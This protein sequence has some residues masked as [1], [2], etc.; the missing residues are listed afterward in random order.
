LPA[1]LSLHVALCVSRLI[2]LDSIL[3][4]VFHFVRASLSSGPFNRFFFILGAVLSLPLCACPSPS[5]PD[6]S[7]PPGRCAQP[8]LRQAPILGCS[9]SPPAPP[10]HTPVHACGPAHIR[11]RAYVRVC[12][13]VCVC[14]CVVCVYVCV[15]VCKCVGVWVV[16]LRRS[17]STSKTHTRL[18]TLSNLHVRP[19]G[20]HAVA[21][22]N[23]KRWSFAEPTNDLG[24][25]AS[26]LKVDLVDLQPYIDHTNCM[27]SY[28]SHQHVA[29]TQHTTHM[30][31]CT[32]I[33][34]YKHTHTHTHMHTHICGASHLR[35]CVSEEGHQQTPLTTFETH[36]HT[37]R[38][39]TNAHTH[40]HTAKPPTLDCASVRKGTNRHL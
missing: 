24:G 10:P 6:P 25:Q 32:P 17:A 11:N 13:C 23:F 29:N 26:Y 4:V 31:T 12:V 33:R 1:Y 16:Y 14:A 38:K 35:A 30:Y 9:V 21:E 27:R 5:P 36:T 37:T 18:C 19:D 3:C 2:F 7:I 28:G 15:C 39:H 34:K 40:T 22:G 20:Q 8:L